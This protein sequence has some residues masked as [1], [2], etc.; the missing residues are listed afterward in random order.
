MTRASPT[1]LSASVRQRLLNLVKERGEELQTLLTRYAVER[2]LYRLGRSDDRDRLVLKGAVLFY[3]WEGGLRRPTRDVDF[4]GYGDPM[5]EKIAE[6]FRSLC[7]VSAEADGLDFHVDSVR[8]EAIRDRQDY[9]GVRVTLMATLGNAR[10]PLQVDVGFGDAVTPGTETARFPTLLDFPEPTIRVYPPETVIAEKY[11]AMVSLGMINTRLKDFY[12]VYALSEEHAFD[13][14]TLAAAVTATFERRGTPL[15]AKPPVALTRMFCDDSTK[16][17]QWRAFLSRGRLSDVPS[18][19]GTI[20][21]RLADFL[22][23]PTNAARRAGDF[24]AAWLPSIG[25]TADE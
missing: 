18:S 9:G 6:L 16:P 1:N 10:I 11:Q 4:L 17:G 25:W 8:A 15:P 7:Q 20:T 13:G 12:D 22:W 3:V 24:A 5:P 14:A 2:L 21:D 19:L 23:P